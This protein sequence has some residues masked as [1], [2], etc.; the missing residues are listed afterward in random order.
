MTNLKNNSFNQNNDKFENHKNDGYYL[1]KYVEKWYQ[2]AWRPSMAF[3]YMILCIIDYGVRPFINYY[4]KNKQHDLTKI[5]KEIKEIS[6][7]MVQI[8][9]LE[10]NSKE[11]F[12]PILNEFVHLAFGAILGISAFSRNEEKK[13]NREREE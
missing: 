1:G 4:E 3:V 9:L 6:D 12:E 13:K 5:V 8:K 11:K 2:R 10:Y 7:P